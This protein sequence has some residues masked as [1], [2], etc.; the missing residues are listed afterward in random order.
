ME[1]TI[2]TIRDGK[3]DI[4]RQGPITGDQLAAF[5]EVRIVKRTGKIVAPGQLESHYAPRTRLRLIDNA[6]S[7]GPEGSQ[8]VALLAWNEIN[9]GSFVAVRRL[10]E[11]GNLREAAANLFRYLRELDALDVDLIVAE[12]VPEQGLGA[13]IMDRLGRAESVDRGADHR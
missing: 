7:F 4:L 10:S 5:A 9:D 2:V 6:A 8:R 13:A 12:R 11:K 1:S 3:I